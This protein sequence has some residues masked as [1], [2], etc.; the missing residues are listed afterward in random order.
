MSLKS[1]VLC[2]DEKIVRVLRRVLNDLEIEIEHCTEPDGA[3]RKLTR[4]RFEAIIIDCTDLKTAT[5]VLKSARSAPVNKR[6]IAVA[7]MDGHNGL[8]SAFDMGAHFVLYKPV[9]TERAK[10][11]FRAARAL[12]KRERRRNARVPVQVQATLNNRLSGFTQKVSSTD[13]SEGGMAIQM[14]KRHQD[15]GPWDVSFTLPGSETLFELTGEVAWHNPGGQV[16]IRFA[17]LAVDVAYQL[18]QWLNQ[19]APEAEKDDPPVRCKLTDLSLGGCYLEITSPFPVRTRIVLA[20]RM[21][22]IELR[23]E[24][25]VRVMHPEIGMGVEFT[26]KT[27]EQRDHVEK[28]IHALMNAGDTLPELMV[29]PEGLEGEVTVNAKR[30][31]VGSVSEVEDP[32]LDL[33]HQKASLPSELFLNELRKQRRSHHSESS[34]ETILPV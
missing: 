13:L 26:Q 15:A 28:F 11:S 7:I 6:A 19:N 31:G 4:Q 2:S 14:P 29:E 10:S 9:S 1:L 18:R 24:G 22:E 21:A 23:V 17:N 5:A 20:M 32:L 30:S 27:T 33:F 3:L 34:E 8:R 12:M 16:G 25:V